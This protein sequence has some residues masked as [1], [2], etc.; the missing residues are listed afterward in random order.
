M[1]TVDLEESTIHQV[2]VAF[3]TRVDHLI[4]NNIGNNGRMQ[5]TKDAWKQFM[6]ATGFNEDLAN[7]TIIEAIEDAQRFANNVKNL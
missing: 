5:E 7:E 2:R 6:L 4:Q 3:R 1:T